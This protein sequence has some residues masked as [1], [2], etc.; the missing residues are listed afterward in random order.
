MACIDSNDRY[1]ETVAPVVYKTRRPEWNTMYQ[2]SY[3]GKVVA[4]HG[5]DP[6]I[7]FMGDVPVLL[8]LATVYTGNLSI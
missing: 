2:Y 8:D 6:V 3:N 5:L 7:M 1:T 4:L